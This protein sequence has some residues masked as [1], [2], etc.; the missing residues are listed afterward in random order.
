MCPTE[1][2]ENMMFYVECHTA[3]DWKTGKIS[4]GVIHNPHYFE[5]RSKGGIIDREIGDIRCGRQVGNN[6]TVLITKYIQTFYFHK[7]L[8]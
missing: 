5:W 1:D 7:Q 6:E 2:I 8:L 4:T 3:F